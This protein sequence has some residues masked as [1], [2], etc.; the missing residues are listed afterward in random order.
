MISGISTHV[1]LPQRLT[2]TL[3]DALREG[4]ARA[5]E[6]FSARWHFDSGDRQQQREIAAWFR[7]NDVAATLHAPLSTDSHFSRHAGPDINL[8]DRD[9]G[10]RLQAMDEIKRA[11]EAAEQIAIATCVLHLGNRD[12]RWD[13]Y[14]LEHS[15][16]AIE[17]LKA[18]AA[19]LGATLLLENLRNDVATPEHLLE[20]LKAGHFDSCGICLDVGHLHVTETDAAETFALLAGRIGELH[21]HDNHGA[22][23]SAG[24]EHLWPVSGTERASTVS[25]GTMDWPQLYALIETLPEGVPG[26][27]EIADTQAGTPSQVTRLAREVFAHQQRLL[28]P[29]RESPRTT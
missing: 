23:G 15:L 28:E 21:L 7:S 20:V 13:E 26:M 19:P 9:K 22:E 11:L 1:F 8:V 16:T 18:F 5:I 10:K 25:T 17:H 29:M 27:L 3:L 4:G 2:T 24:D 6:L 12:D 14:V